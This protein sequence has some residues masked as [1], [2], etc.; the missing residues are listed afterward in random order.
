MDKLVVR[1]K[2]LKVEAEGIIKKG[3]LIEN[4]RPFGEVV[5]KGSFA[6]DLMIV[7]DI[8]ISVINPKANCKKSCISAFNRFAEDGLFQSCHYFN[9]S[10]WRREYF[11]KGY[12]LGLQVPVGEVKWKVDI[13]FIKEETDYEKTIVPKLK[14]LSDEKRLL[15]LQL[16][17]YRNENKLDVSSAD[18]YKMVLEDKLK[19][20]EDLK[21]INS[22][23]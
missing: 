15:I 3:K 16:K 19:S 17:H 11:P 22:G 2:K 9:W 1:S 18:I 4:L 10:D 21:K 7:E 23:S 8:D 6:L 13:W 14:K 20:I 5:L 12:Y